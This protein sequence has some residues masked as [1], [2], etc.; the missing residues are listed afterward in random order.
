MR[1]GIAALT[2]IAIAPVAAQSPT[3]VRGNPAGEWRYWAADAWST[4]YSPLDQINAKNFDSLQVAWQWSAAPLGQ[5]EY[6]RS[7]PLFANG[8]LF[9]VATE[10]RVAVAIDPE[11]GQ[12]L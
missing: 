8:R 9:T 7:T 3:L 4:R 10:R 6:F 1:L 11:N 5:D 12:T 2:L